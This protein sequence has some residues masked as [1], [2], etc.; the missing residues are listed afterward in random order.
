MLKTKVL[1]NFFFQSISNDGTYKGYDLDLV[2]FISDN[3]TIP[4]V[5]CGGCSSFDDF[6]DLVSIDGIS[7]YA[8][9][10]VFVFFGPR[11]AVLINYP[12]I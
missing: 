3:T 10:S 4:I 9:G 8:A 2:N 11:K 12:E 1:E 6:K 7:G 5:P